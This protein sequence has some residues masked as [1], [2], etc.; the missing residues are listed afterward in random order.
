MRVN[1]MDDYIKKHWSYKSI[2]LKSG[3]RQLWVA[4]NR[5]FLEVILQ[6]N[7]IINQW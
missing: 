7:G 6:M 1:S 4:N 3:N 2:S 5:L